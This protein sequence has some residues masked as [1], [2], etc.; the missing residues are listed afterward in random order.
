MDISTGRFFIRRDVTFHEDIFPFKDMISSTPSS[1][2][3]RLF[4]F[5]ADLSMAS[6]YLLVIPEQSMLVIQ[7]SSVS[8]A[9]SEIGSPVVSQALFEEVPATTTSPDYIKTS[10]ASQHLIADQPRRSSRQ[11]CPPT[12][13]KDYIC[14]VLGSLGTKYPVSSYVSFNWLSPEYMCCI[15][16]LSEEH[17]PSSFYEAS[18]DPR[19]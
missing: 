7:E 15:S 19:W 11:T 4:L 16:C 13:T 3:K 2:G 17:E 5:E 12:W 8:L 18:C 1:E 10:P 6:Q 9:S 14:L